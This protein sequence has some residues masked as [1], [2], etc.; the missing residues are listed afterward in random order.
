[1]C[2][3]PNALAEAAKRIKCELDVFKLFLAKSFI[4]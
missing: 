3:S 4:I 1:M 2:D